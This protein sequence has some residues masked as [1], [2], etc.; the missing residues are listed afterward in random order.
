[1]L[2]PHFVILLACFVL[3]AGLIGCQ[4]DLSD[5][6]IDRMAEGMVEALMT[7]PRYLA[8]LEDEDGEMVKAFANAM[9]E[10]PSYQTT[11]EEDCAMF[12]LMATV[13]SGDYTMPPDS[14]S[15]RLCA[16]YIRQLE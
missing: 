12:I 5:E 2:K 11:Q 8:Y 1:M 3:L 6:E 14:D 16:W 7:N 15:D 4:N 13:Q 9:L 10:H